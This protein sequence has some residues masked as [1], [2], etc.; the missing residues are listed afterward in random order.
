MTPPDLHTELTCPF[1]EGRN[2][3]VLRDN[4]HKWF[5]Y[6]EI[7]EG[8]QYVDRALLGSVRK[9]FYSL[10]IVD[11]CPGCHREFIPNAFSIKAKL[12]PICN[13]GFAQLKNILEARDG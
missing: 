12:C 8:E 6:I 9:D 13:S 7:L 4:K 2:E 10:D 11:K 5:N 1:L 3:R